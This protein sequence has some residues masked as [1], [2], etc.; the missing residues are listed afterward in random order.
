MNIQKSQCTRCG[1]ELSALAAEGLC[2]GCLLGRALMSDLEED[3]EE[4]GAQRIGDYDL[5]EQIAR[6]GMGLVYRA[7]HRRLNRIV[8]LKL[9]SANELAK[10][11]Y[12][13]RFRIEA[14]A[15]ASLNH[16]HIVP[17]YEV[18]EESG[19]HF[20]SM[21]L[22]EGGSLS[23]RLGREPRMSIKDS[24][25]LLVKLARAVHYA[26][27][28][29]ILHRDIKP[30]NVL[31]DATGEPLLADFGLAKLIE[32]NSRIT[33]TLALLGTP[34]YISPEQAAG[35]GGLTTSVDVYGLGA[36]FFEMLTGSPP[37]AGGTTMATVR[38]VLEK[39]PER[40]SRRNSEVDRDLETICL[41]CLE[42]S[43]TVRYA[44]AEA[45]AEDLERWERGESITARPSTSLVRTAKWMRRHPGWS[46]A[47]G[48]VAIATVSVVIISNVARSRVTAALQVSRQQTRLIA[49]QE[50]ELSRRQA[51][52]VRQLER[53]LFLQGV[54][55]AQDDRIGPALA[56]W[57]ESLR[58]DFGNNAAAAC[59]FHA[60]TQRR[61]MQP[62]F[63]PVEN[64]GFVWDCAFSLDGSRLAILSSGEKAQ[65]WMRDSSTGRLLFSTS[66]GGERGQ[67]VFSPDGRHVAVSSGLVGWGRAGS[68]R[69]LD[70]VTGD[71]L[72]P[73]IPTVE[74][75]WDLQYSPDGSALAFSVH[76]A[77]LYV[78][79]AIT[80]AVRFTAPRVP[81]PGMHRQI[82][83]AFDSQSLYVS[84][85]PTAIWHFDAHTGRLIRRWDDP[86][87]GH[88]FELRLAPK[89]DWIAS[90]G[91]IGVRLYSTTDGTA[92]RQITEPHLVTWADVSPDGERLL[93]FTVDG[94]IR[95]WSAR[96]GIETVTLDA[97]TP[98]IRAKFDSS[99]RR[100]VTHGWD[101]AARVWDLQAGRPLCEPLRH[102]SRVTV[103]LFSPTGERLATG[104]ANG[105]VA[106]W[107][108]EEARATEVRMEMP[109]GVESACFSHAGNL[110]AATSEEGK[111][112]LWHRGERDP[113]LTMSTPGNPF[114][115]VIFSPDDRWLLT[116]GDQAVQV[117]DA[118]TGQAVGQPLPHATRAIAAF[119]PDGETVATAER[120][121]FED[122][123]VGGTEGALRLWDWRSGRLRSPPV[124]QERLVAALVY[125][126]DGSQIL[127]SHYNLSANLN[128]AHT[129]VRTRHLSTGATLN[130]VRYVRGGRWIQAFNGYRPVYFDATTL[131]PVGPAIA[132]AAEASCVTPTEDGAHIILA[133]LDNFVR[134]FDGISGIESLEPIAHGG[135]VTRIAVDPSGTR[136]AVGGRSGKV[137]VYDMETGKPI[138]GP[139]WHDPSHSRN[140][141]LEITA[142][143][144]SRDGSQLLTA[145]TDHTA[146][147]WDMG[148]QKGDPIP[149]WLPELAESVGGVRLRQPE[150]NGGVPHLVSVPYKERE[151]ARTRLTG[152]DET[153]A[154]GQMAR[155]FYT[156]PESQEGTYRQNRP[157]KMP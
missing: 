69:V 91:G 14:E 18:G 73:P 21:R 23:E 19:R 28:R 111:A 116:E 146:R 90:C 95:L 144:F 20:F 113:A 97:S 50:Q 135:P 37:F 9:I 8:A 115:R 109:A 119:S 78:I 136:F 104:T 156:P 2:P 48:A 60:L 82:V 75:M 133:T 57:A 31:M 54:Q 141:A 143:E 118:R 142:L 58:L 129:G 132:S 103:S 149:G 83:W 88:P 77:E 76:Q 65:F 123:G 7:R 87:G 13:E 43:P 59:I 12:V 11:E 64:H 62:A 108:L 96:D 1:R 52:T 70:A 44:S 145:G 85:V 74:G 114:H 79:D 32:A 126:P 49:E 15:A 138:T 101:N 30:S 92:R 154:W 105:G 35:T 120:N 124:P 45:L 36:V 89:S 151:A 134:V 24:V 94:R 81:D 46:T 100:L 86:G 98:Q 22:A 16:P 147:L 34:A 107:N 148:P 29:G 125:S 137:V 42:K 130:D 41:K 55:A 39:E 150:G 6:G 40:P 112:R 110:I 128:D 56:Y 102:S 25:R 122:Q 10:P 68:V 152:L 157:E 5:L 38:M 27:Q 80:G 47:I 139:L 3:L 61:F 99:G 71:L 63:A 131:K 84:S 51:T 26:H 121:R 106:I 72:F 140:S 67:V 155:W 117:W 33:H 66:L 17:I 4:S 127:T 153:N 53:S 93:T